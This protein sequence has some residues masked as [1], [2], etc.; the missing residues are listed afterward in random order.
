MGPGVEINA[1]SCSFPGCSEIN[2]MRHANASGNKKQRQEGDLGPLP[3]ILLIANNAET[4]V[5]GSHGAAVRSD[6]SKGTSYSN[7]GFRI[8]LK[9]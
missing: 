6:R 8:R 4:V 1:I 2:D 7:E 3:S 5:N 9:I